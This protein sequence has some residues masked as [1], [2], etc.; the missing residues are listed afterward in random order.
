M[1]KTKQYQKAITTVLYDYD[2]AWALSGGLE[3]RII[4]DFQRNTFVMLTFGWQN[5]ETYTHLLCFHIEIIHDKIWIH[6][7]N[8]DAMIAVDLIELGVNPEDIILGFAEPHTPV[9]QIGSTTIHLLNAP[10]IQ[11]YP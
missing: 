10:P 7:N 4:A 9:K 2:S 11:V 8:T 6:E 1:N 5:K 3:N